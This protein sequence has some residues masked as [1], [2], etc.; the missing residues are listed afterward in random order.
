MRRGEK[1]IAVLL[2]LFIIGLP[3]Y[4]YYSVIYP[5]NLF[6]QKLNSLAEKYKVQGISLSIEDVQRIYGGIYGF[7]LRHVYN[8]DEFMNT[9][10]QMTVVYINYNKI[11]M[12]IWAFIETKDI[13]YYIQQ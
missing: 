13:I 12:S 9:L 8:F 10:S 5:K 4:Y 2:I 3:S 6:D 11:E 7:S 1:V